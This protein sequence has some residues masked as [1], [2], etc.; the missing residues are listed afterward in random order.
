MHKD[1]P[2]SDHYDFLFTV[3]LRNIQAVLP[4]DKMKVGD[5]SGAH[6]YIKSKSEVLNSTQ[7]QIIPSIIV[8]LLVPENYS[9][10]T[11]TKLW[12]YIYRIFSLL[13]TFIQPQNEGSWTQTLI[14]FYKMFCTRFVARV[15]YEKK[16]FLLLKKLKLKLTQLNNQENDSEESI[17]LN[18]NGINSEG[19]EIEEPDDEIKHEIDPKEDNFEHDYEQEEYE[20]D[21]ELMRKVKQIH[22]KEESMSDHNQR[23]DYLQK[24][25]HQLEEKSKFYLDQQNIDNF[26]QI[27]LKSL[28]Y[29]V[30]SL[31]HI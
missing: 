3:F 7:L 22:Q 4:H 18:L 10:E 30:L 21:F 20:D 8:S 15:I 12:E 17:L 24:K 27:M 1:L 31:I 26:M 14:N 28:K 11:F 6:F 29:L 13:E 2:W 25:I 5:M 23:I 16:T 19:D 9:K